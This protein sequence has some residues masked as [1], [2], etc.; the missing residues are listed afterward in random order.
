MKKLAY[1]LLLVVL[2][3]SFSCR[4]KNNL[5]YNYVEIYHEDFSSVGDWVFTTDSLCEATIDSNTLTLTATDYLNHYYTSTAYSAYPSF[6]Q[7]SVY[8]EIKFKT[9]SLNTDWAATISKNFSIKIGNIEIQ[10]TFSNDH[11]LL[12]LNNKTL[13]IFVDKSQNQL[14]AS[15]KETGTDYS[16]RFKLKEQSPEEFSINFIATPYWS[17]SGSFGVA[18]KLQVGDILIYSTE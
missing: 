18:T 10:P 12:N 16:H 3:V 13:K 8:I 11:E 6:N 5:H 17:F 9:F 7:N 14:S 4:K 1:L 15:I 2:I